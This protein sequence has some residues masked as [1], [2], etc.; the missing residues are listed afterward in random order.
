MPTHS[1]PK[2]KPISNLAVTALLHDLNEELDRKKRKKKEE[3]D[4]SIKKPQSSIRRRLGPRIDDQ[5][6][7]ESIHG[8]GSQIFGAI[9]MCNRR[10]RR[11][12]LRHRLFG[13]PIN[14]KSLVE[15]VVPGMM[16]FLFEFE[17]RELWGVF[18]ATSYGDMDIVPNAYSGGSFPCQVHLNLHL[19]C[20]RF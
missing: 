1:K 13:L 11:E 6:V 3:D 2:P 14:K 4:S 20:I 8:H 5:D 7:P 10:T 12:C 19:L 9:F 15:Q 16:L 18:E 17:R